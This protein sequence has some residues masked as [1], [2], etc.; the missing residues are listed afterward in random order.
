MASKRLGESFYLLK[1]TLVYHFNAL[2]VCV[3]E[4]QSSSKV[5]ELKMLT[6]ELERL[7]ITCVEN[8]HEIV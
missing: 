3:L 4:K 2:C 5:A 7:S 8:Q 1:Q 6:Q